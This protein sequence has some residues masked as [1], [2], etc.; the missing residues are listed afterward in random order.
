MN[1]RDQTDQEKIVS[2]TDLFFFGS[3][4]ASFTAAI[5][6]CFVPQLLV[7]RPFFFGMLASL[8]THK[9]LGKLGDGEVTDF[10]SAIGNIKVT[11]PIAVLLISMV[12][13]QTMFYLFERNRRFILDPSSN[14]IVVFR[15]KKGQGVDVRLKNSINNEDIYVIKQN[16]IA[17]SLFGYFI[18][19]CYLDKTLGC[20]KE[21]EFVVNDM[22]T[23]PGNA[24]VC[25]GNI[26]GVR[27]IMSKKEVSDDGLGS[28]TPIKLYANPACDTSENLKIYISQE[29]ARKAE[30]D[31]KNNKGEG[32]ISPF[33]GDVILPK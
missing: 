23:S 29:D 32:F 6:S 3:S 13:I 28:P 12:S 31:L 11:G 2:W 10:Q 20:K 17:S 21:V 19:R 18:E 16:E 14:E 1:D 27:V 30:I 8:L 22:I 7:T 5:I 15:D 25:K 26:S 24:V 33:L 4:I 9:L